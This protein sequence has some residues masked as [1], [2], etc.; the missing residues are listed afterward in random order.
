L[1]S[2]TSLQEPQ[3]RLAS[4]ASE[5]LGADILAPIPIDALALAPGVAP[6]TEQLPYRCRRVCLKVDT[7]TCHSKSHTPETNERSTQSVRAVS[8]HLCWQ[9]RAISSTIISSLIVGFKL[10][11]STS[12]PPAHAHLVDAGRDL[13]EP[14]LAC[15]TECIHDLKLL[16]IK[17]HHQHKQAYHFGFGVC[18]VCT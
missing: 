17:A 15:T 8:S 1:P 16:S 14:L 13:I 7:V 10:P 12:T 9:Q 5:V 11:N 3:P 18:L 2:S 6:R 4:V